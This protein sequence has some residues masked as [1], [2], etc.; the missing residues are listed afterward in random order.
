MP[1][2]NLLNKVSESGYGGLSEAEFDTLKQFTTA[3]PQY[4][5]LFNK[6]SDSGFSALSDKEFESL[7][8]IPTTAPAPA[9]ERPLEDR[10]RITNKGPLDVASDIYGDVRG[11]MSVLASPVVGAWNTL[12]GSKGSLND[13]SWQKYKDNVAAAIDQGHE[14]RGVPGLIADPMNVLGGPL[15]RGATAPFVRLAQTSRVA[16]LVS[17]AARLAETPVVGV[18]LRGFARGAAHGAVVGGASSLDPTVDY[19]FAQGAL[20]GGLFGGALG[21][22]GELLQSS[23][24][25]NFPGLNL[26]RPNRNVPLE[27]RQYVADNL[28]EI[29]QPKKL[30]EWW[31][32]NTAALEARAEARL[33]QMSGKYEAGLQAL[34]AA[35]PN[36]T[37]D[38]RNVE[39]SANRQAVADLSNFDTPYLDYR[40]DIAAGFALPS[41]SSE[42]ISQVYGGMRGSKMAQLRKG[43][44][45][46]ERVNGEFVM[47]N[48]DPLARVKSINQELNLNQRAHPVLSGHAPASIEARRFQPLMSKLADDPTS[49]GRIIRAENQAVQDAT[50]AARTYIPSIRGTAPFTHNLRERAFAQGVGVGELKAMET[51]IN[52]EMANRVTP[53]E[54]SLMRSAATRPEYYRD[55]SGQVQD[56]KKITGLSARDAANQV[57]ESYPEYSKAL[58]LEKRAPKG[59]VISQG[60][61]KEQFALDKGLLNVLAHPGRTGLQ[62]RL[63]LGFTNPAVEHTSVQSAKYL[64]GELMKR[65]LISV[66]TAVGGA[67]LLFGVPS[68]DEQ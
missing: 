68:R 53:K 3:N 40:P 37:I 58:G 20:G 36:L 13:L 65:G 31:P 16:P 67:R 46:P 59:K 6:V 7:K 22:S 32:A 19:N 45:G 11:G 54:L 55:P 60:N 30:T 34:D 52:E 5:P 38:L 33:D 4:K 25:A 57:L 27:T 10:V 18:P 17:R 43:M 24:K 35:H 12:T 26:N 62:H 61:V 2:K 42:L 48:I 64:A 44:T 23:A 63:N 28:D 51:A 39:K 41:T 21:A 9:Q 8:G 29:L 1:V 15:V 56:I 49:I 47:G 14:G 66:P 50:A